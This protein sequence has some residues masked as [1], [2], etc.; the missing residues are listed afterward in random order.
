MII[1]FLQICY[2]DRVQRLNIYPP[3][4]FPLISSWTAQ[5]ITN[6]L[7]LEKDFG[8]GYGTILDRIDIPIIVDDDEEV[9]NE[10]GNDFQNKPSEADGDGEPSSIEVYTVEY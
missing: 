8:Y 5:R 3:R 7:D 9:P 4:D 1:L 10:A 6:R 2:F